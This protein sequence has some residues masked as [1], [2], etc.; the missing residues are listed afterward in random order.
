MPELTQNQK[1]LEYLKSG[2]K[3]TPITAL[4]KFGCFRLS[5][6]IYN[7]KQE[8]HNIITENVTR[9]GK[10]FAEYSLEVK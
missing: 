4:N 6:R 10:T 3:L 5:A 2:K 7:L 8:G 1:I 9:K